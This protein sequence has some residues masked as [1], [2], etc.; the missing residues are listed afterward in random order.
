MYTVY[1]PVFIRLTVCIYKLYISVLTY[2]MYVYM[3]NMA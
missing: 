2:Y 3:Y 1:T